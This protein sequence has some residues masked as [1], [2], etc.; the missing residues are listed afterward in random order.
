MSIAVQC[1]ACHR[2]LKVKDELAGKRVKCTCGQIVA[3]PAIQI[4]AQIDSSPARRA[5]WLWYAGGAVILCGIAVTL[6]IIAKSDSD[7]SVSRAKL[8][9]KWTGSF[10]NGTIDVDF[11]ERLAEVKIQAGGGLGMGRV[12]YEING[13]QIK[14]GNAV[15]KMTGDDTLVISGE[16]LF[17]GTTFGVP[18]TKLER[19]ASK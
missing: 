8:L 7:K 4:E 17:G 14:V 2:K 9:G 5:R 16:F 1:G 18:S 10:D 3:V 11:N 15:A 12:S 13:S 6:I 19:V